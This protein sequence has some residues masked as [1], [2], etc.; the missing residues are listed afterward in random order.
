MGRGKNV[1]INGSWKKLILVFMDNF[2]GFKT[3]VEQGTSNVVEIA[4]EQK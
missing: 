4:G 3:S 2:E 1:N